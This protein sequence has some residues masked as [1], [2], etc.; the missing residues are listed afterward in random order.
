[1]ISKCTYIHTNYYNKHAPLRPFVTKAW[2]FYCRMQGFMPGAQPW[3]THSFDPGSLH[4]SKSVTQALNKVNAES[5]GEED[6]ARPS[7]DAMANVPVAFTSAMSSFFP[8]ASKSRPD[9]DTVS[10][11]G[12]SQ[13]DA[14]PPPLSSSI[15]PT[16]HPDQVPCPQRNHLSVNLALSCSTSSE[17]RT[18]TTSSAWKRKCNVTGDMWPPSTKWASKNKLDTLNPVIISNQLNSTLTC[19]ADVMESLWMLPLHPLRHQ[20]IQHLYHY[21]KLH[22]CW[23]PLNLQFLHLHYHLYHPPIPK[24]LIR[25]SGSS[26]LIRIFIWG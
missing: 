19:L 21:L 9:L 7:V 2:P 8:P 18:P 25:H 16:N 24:S 26:L 14:M 15:S 10:L 4:T 11:G 12:T 13:S 20:L 1:M 5:D 3:G 17:T 6:Q 23:Y 22:H